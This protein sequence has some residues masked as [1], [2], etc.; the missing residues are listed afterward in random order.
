MTKS[1][2]NKKKT[3]CQHTSTRVWAA[4]V[5][6]FVLFFW[7][8]GASGV[9]RISVGAVETHLA[10]TD[11]GSSSA[12]AT[13]GRAGDTVAL[14]K[15]GFKGTGCAS[16]KEREDNKK[17][18]IK[19]KKKCSAVTY[20]KDKWESS[21]VAQNNNRA[22]SEA[23][24]LTVYGERVDMRVV[25]VERLRH[26]L[27]SAHLQLF[28]HYWIAL[29]GD[30]NLLK[31][32]GRDDSEVPCWKGREE[33]RGKRGLDDEDSLLTGDWCCQANGGETLLREGATPKEPSISVCSVLRSPKPHLGIQ[34]NPPHACRTAL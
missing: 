16:W 10:G 4:L 2:N 30:I 3:N 29:P 19:E 11:I 6:C 15:F 20:L 32:R 25:N 22:C 28:S 14:P 12:G 7:L 33:G 21:S 31:D 26:G 34:T 27:S 18:K 8:T 13:V 17:T 9:R 5:F 24:L 23:A 1:N